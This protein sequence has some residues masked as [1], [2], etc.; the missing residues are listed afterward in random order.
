MH[1]PAPALS[2]HIESRRLASLHAYCILDTPT[3]PV[4]DDI[5]RIA[6][7]VCQ[8]PIAVVNLIDADRQWFKAE[9][10]LGVRQASMDASICTHVFLEHDYLEI[11]DTTQDPRFACNPLVVGEPGYRFYAGA[12]LK[13]PDGLPIGTVCVL[14]TR[15]RRLTPEQA[16]TLRALARQVMAQLE[17]RRLL[18]EA[19]AVSAQRARVLASAGHDL[20]IPLRAAFYAIHRARA[21]AREE[22]IARL[23]HAEQEL[24]AIQQKFGEL[25][26]SATGRGGFVPPSLDVADVAPMLDQVAASWQRAA[27][28]KA[29]T[30]TARHEQSPCLA[31]THAGL[32]ETLLGNL[33]SNAVKYTPSG[34][35]VDLVCRYE[36]GLA[37]I[38]VIDTGVGMD[39]ARVDRYFEAF[40]QGDAQSEGLG[41]GLWIV[42]QTAEALAADL[43]VASSPG[44]GT[45]ITVRLPPG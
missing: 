15:P 28:R 14:D 32:L 9:V 39:P 41:L 6:S 7:T 19:H 44:E 27:T 38:D 17:L 10:G 20:Q 13:T 24:N 36:H 42:R 25:I 34:G 16:D 43:D 35:R 5:S 11:P 3:E 45:R 40:Q 18:A 12:L 1:Q 31:C 4:F 26:A 33:V 30:L 2:E 29:V 23:D 37:C 22:Q 21:G 8:T